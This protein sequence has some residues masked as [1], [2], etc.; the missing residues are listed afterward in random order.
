MTVSDDLS[1]K[2]SGPVARLRL[3]RRFSEALLPLETARLDADAETLGATRQ[4]T[5]ATLRT[6]LLIRTLDLRI[7]VCLLPGR[8][9]SALDDATVVEEAGHLLHDNP[10]TT[11]VVIVTDDKELSA[12][13]IEPYDTVSGILSHAKSL[14][15]AAGVDKFDKSAPVLVRNYLRQVDTP[16]VHAERVTS[17]LEDLES[18]AATCAGAALSEL[19]SKRKNVPEWKAA[20]EALSGADARWAAKMARSLIS[21]DSVDV[22]TELHKTSLRG[23]RDH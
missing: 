16:W 9:A 1:A 19:K 17:D 7:R 8:S 2:S 11:A 22:F 15:G 18:I 23:L 20:R 4:R 21:A 14:N 6:D 10:E 12:R 5:N 13:I 3:A